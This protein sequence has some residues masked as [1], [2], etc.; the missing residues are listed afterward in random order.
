MP[1]YKSCLL[2]YGIAIVES[3]SFLFLDLEGNANIYVAIKSGPTVIETFLNVA[4]LSQRVKVFASRDEYF[5]SHQ[6]S[7]S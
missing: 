1:L 3:L 2:T 5:S 7:L 6:N 4:C